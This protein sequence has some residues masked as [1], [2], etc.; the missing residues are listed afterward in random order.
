MRIHIDYTKKTLTPEQ[1]R[2]TVKDV[3][4]FISFVKQRVHKKLKG[5]ASRSYNI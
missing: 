1:K 5:T 2:R 4:D 3:N